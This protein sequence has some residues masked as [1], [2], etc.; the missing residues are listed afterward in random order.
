M[1]RIIFRCP[2]L[3]GGT[4][5]AAAHLENYVGYVATREGVERIDPGR[6]HL[7]ATQKQRAMVQ[8]LLREFP[9]SKGMFEYADYQAAPT[10]GNASEFITRAI[11]DNLDSLAK[12]ENYL[13]YIAKRPRAQRMGPH[14]LF[15]GAEDALVLSQ[16][17]K[18]VANHQGNVWLPIISLRREDAARLGY[19]SAHAWRNL[20]RAH[21]NDIAS[22]MKIPP[23]DF[24]WYAAFH[25]EG[26]HPHVHMM[27]WSAKPGLAHLSCEGIRQS[28]LRSRT[29]SSSK[30]CSMSTSR[31][32]PAE[33]SWYGWRGGKC[34]SWC[35][36]CRQAC[37]TTPRWKR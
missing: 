10:R 29:T 5:E 16:V 24:R 2:Y 22:A 17:A 20:I 18:E 33:T 1:P 21:R 36:P 32:P 25:D 9:L 26:E 35:V 13:D 31:S 27:A 14:G 15:T 4:E 7:P 28:N 23:K 6:A 11:E 8:K 34:W 30:S 3:K 12:R 19:D 37:A